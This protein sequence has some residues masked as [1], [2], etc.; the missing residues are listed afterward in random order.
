MADRSMSDAASNLPLHRETGDVRLHALVPCAGSGSRAR[1]DVPK[2]YQSLAGKPL[3]LHTLAALAGVPR[4]ATTLV[5]VAPGDATLAAQPGIMLAECG[6]PTRAATVRN[7][8]AVL[9]GQGASGDDWV[10]VHDAARCLVTPA[11]VDRLIDACLKDEVG[12][13]LAQPLADTL[14][15]SEGDRVAATV[16]RERLWQAQTP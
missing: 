5:C 9:A 7:G 13:L 3:V 15:R 10:L 14:K 6:G 11:L 4:L 2:Q 16:P 12:G 1:T 8:L